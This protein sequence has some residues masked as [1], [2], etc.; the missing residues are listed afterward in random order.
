[1]I[2]CDVRIEEGMDIGTSD[3]DDGTE[4]V[5]DAV[6]LPDVEG[7]SGCTLASVSCTAEF[8]LGRCD[9]VGEFLRSTVFVENG[10]ISNNDELDE[11]PLGP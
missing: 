1:M 4:K 6:F 5:G 2:G 9:E 7:F 8:G 10:L 11:V 3:I